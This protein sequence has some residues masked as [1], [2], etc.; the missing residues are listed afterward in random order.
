MSID[1]VE[2]FQLRKTS[3]WGRG[4]DPLEDGPEPDDPGGSSYLSD[5]ASYLSRFKRE[6][7]LTLGRV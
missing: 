6:T 2:D 1:M 3:S 4:L 7:L 5:L